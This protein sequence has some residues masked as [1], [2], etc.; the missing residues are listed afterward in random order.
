MNIDKEFQLTRRGFVGGI[1][2]LAAIGSFTGALALSNSFRKDLLDKVSKWND[3]AQGALYSN[4]KLAPTYSLDQI[5]NNFPYNGF[6]PQAY[7][8]RLN[9]LSWRLELGGLVQNKT[10]LSLADLR[11]MQQES[12]I[13]RLI[14]IEGWSAVGQW[15]GVPLHQ[16]LRTIGA[17]LKDTFVRIDCADGYYTSID[18]ESALHPQTILALD[19]L[20]K[21][22]SRAFGAPVRLRIPVKLGFKNA[23]FITGISVHKQP[24]GGYWEEQGYNW[25]SGL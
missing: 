2:S 6:Y 25:F 13:T 11:K 21:P 14:C 10:P 16:L 1:A 22:L 9:P 19:F 4:D 7:A 20:G 17:D 5:S 12:Q 8:P 24:Q 15:S 18:I 3:M 23:K